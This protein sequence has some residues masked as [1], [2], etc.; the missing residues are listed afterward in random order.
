MALLQL[1]SSQV[2]GTISFAQGGA[3][4]LATPSR[5][6][7]TVPYSSR[8]PLQI[9][10]HFQPGQQIPSI[11]IVQ[12]FKIGLDINV[13]L[14]NNVSEPRAVLIDRQ[15]KSTALKIACLEIPHREKVLFRDIDT[16]KWHCEMHSKGGWLQNLLGRGGAT[17]RG[18]VII[19]QTGLK[20]IQHLLACF[21]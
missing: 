18:K 2:R 8:R 6:C 4:I 10:K 15:Y 21:Q 9:V 5:N 20:V 7:N 16:V 13:K 19:Q 17:N 14:H 3:S 12:L 11:S 1:V